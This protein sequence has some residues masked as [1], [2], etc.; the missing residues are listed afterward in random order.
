[1][2]R[3]VTGERLGRD[4]GE[5]C[6]LEPLGIIATN[7]IDVLFGSRPDCVVYNPMWLDVDEAQIGILS[8]GVKVRGDGSVHYW[9]QSGW[10]SRTE[11]PRRA[12]L[13]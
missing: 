8:A 5:L 7:D 12:G 3:L 4:V 1:M 2:L 10:S 11:S 9:S 6:G 13:A